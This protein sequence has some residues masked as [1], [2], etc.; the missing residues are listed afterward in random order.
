MKQHSLMKRV[1]NIYPKVTVV[2]PTYNS[3]KFLD[4]CLPPLLSMDYANYDILVVD[5]CSGDSTVEHLRQYYPKIK[6]I[7]LQQ[8][9]GHSA[10]CNTGILATDARYV[11]IVEHHT[12]VTKTALLELVATMLDHPKTAICYSKQLNMYNER[13]IVVEGKRYAH[14]I[15]NQQCERTPFKEACSSETE[16]PVDVTSAGTFSFLLDKEQFST[17][18]YF[19]EDYFIHI[20][21]YEFTFRAKAAGLKCYYVPASVSYHKSFVSTASD[22]NFRGGKKYP[23]CR[24]FF[25]ARN[26]WLL[27]LSYYS[28]KTILVLS[29]AFFLYELGLVGFVIRRNVWKSY[30]KALA[31][32]LTHPVLILEKRRRIQQL[33]R[34]NDASLLVAGDLNFVPGLSQS[35]LER[36]I[37][38][39]LTTFLTTYWNCVKTFL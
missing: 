35:T 11:Y 39:S 19:D 15:V 18:G 25:I 30:L 7:Q 4:Q 34:L 33:K 16:T 5:D 13:E 28:W 32:L 21:D 27:I 12:I 9:S 37:I 17:I 10:A 8:R 36:V 26:R 6:V 38:Q 22:Y 29:P 1:E 20:N 14:Y 3:Q 23:D 31:W 24:T 2:L